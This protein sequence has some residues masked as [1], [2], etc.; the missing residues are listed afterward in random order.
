MKNKSLKY[1]INLVVN[2]NSSFIAINR[3]LQ[4]IKQNKTKTKPPTT[5]RTVQYLLHLK[6]IGTQAGTACCVVLHIL[7][8]YLKT[9]DIIPYCS[10]KLLIESLFIFL[11]QLMSLEFSHE[12]ITF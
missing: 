9:R 3:G 11:F 2:L 10:H 8:Q 5:K 7:S 12:S 1:Q 6:E 4:N